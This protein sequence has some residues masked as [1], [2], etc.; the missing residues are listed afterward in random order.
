MASF[1]KI[2]NYARLRRKL[3]RMP[4]QVKQ[5]AGKEMEKA[6]DTVVAMMRSLVPEQDGTLRSSIGWVWGRAPKGAFAITSVKVSDT[7]L[8]IY[9]GDAEAF[10]ARWVEF[11][12]KAH[13]IKA[14][15]PGGT[16]HGNKGRW[17][18]KHFGSVVNHP[19]ARKQP[20]FFPSWRSNKRPTVRAMRSAIRKA[21]K[22]IAVSGY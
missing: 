15:K 14:K 20:F 21:I 8:T 22:E 10:Y 6:A 7:T 13:T 12:T 2:L 19:G 3:K 16:M 1:V 4:Q 11:G 17:K 9:A 18:G 5:R